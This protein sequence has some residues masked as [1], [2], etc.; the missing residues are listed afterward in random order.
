MSHP[1]GSENVGPHENDPLETPGTVNNSLCSTSCD[2]GDLVRT[3]HD[4]HG[5]PRRS[6]ISISCENSL[7]ALRQLPKHCRDQI[8]E[9]SIPPDVM[10]TDDA[11][12]N[13]HEKELGE[14][15]INEM[16]SVS[17]IT[18]SMPNDLAVSVEKDGS[19]Y[20]YRSWTLH[21]TMIGAICTSARS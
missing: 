19:E 3:W 20:E 2:L 11:N 4:A 8:L 10:A 12:N 9:L 17:V 7:S 15:I 1:H 16:Q 6:R 14:Y 18:L 13:D 5:T 21:E